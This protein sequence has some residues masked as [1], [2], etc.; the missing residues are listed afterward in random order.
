M[1]TMDIFNDDAFSVTSLTKGINETTY[2]PGRISALGLFE[3]EGISTTTVTIEKR[4]NGLVIVAA[5]ERGADGTP[6]VADKGKVIPFT[7]THLP[8]SAKI[9]ADEIIGKRAFGTTEHE[10]VQNVVNKRQQKM[11]NAL[12]V[13]I[14]YQRIGAITGKVL[15]AD[16]TV[17][18][19]IYKAFD[20]EQKS[21]SMAL[22]TAGTK[23]RSNVIKA[24]RMSE[25]AL[26]AAV[27]GYRV[28]C[29]RDFFDAFVEHDSVKDAYQRYN[30]GEMLRNDPRGGFQ[31]AGAI[32]EEYRGKVG[33]KKFIEDDVAYLV[34]EGVADMF[35]THFAPANYMETVGTDGLP[36]YS[37]QEAGPMG[38]YIELEAQSNPLN[39]CTMPQGIIKL[40]K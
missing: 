12:D 26:E 11:R 14:E 8:L 32:W 23:V 22:G 19:D 40:K 18:L 9:H 36:Y 17:L 27:T 6:V 37:K 16:G 24:V 38:K 25:D 29:G 35:V 15:D 33:D 10:M 2:K 3:E 5:K 1:L 13:T 20:I 4:K 34:P 39:L 28:F 7:T 31:Y 30:E 21:V